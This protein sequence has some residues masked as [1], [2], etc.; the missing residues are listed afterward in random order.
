MTQPHRLVHDTAGAD[1]GEATDWRSLTRLGL[2]ALVAGGAVGVVGAAFR[3]CLEAANRERDALIGWARQWPLVGW[4]VPV[5][6]AALLVAVA[7][8]LVQRFAPTAAGSGVQHVEAVMRGE[9]APEPAAVLPVKFVGGVL[10]IGSGLVLGREGPTV[11]IG[12][13]VGAVAARLLRLAEG[14]ARTLQ[15]AGAGAGLAVAFNAPIGG[16]A[17]VVEELT[18]TFRATTMVAA[19]VACASAGA[20]SRAILGNE[21]A[22]PVAP[23]PLPP[24]GAVVSG[25]VLGALL[26]LVGAAYNRAVLLWLNRFAALDRVPVPARA[27][28][29]GG[30]VGLVA[31]F[32]PGLVGGGEPLVERTLAGAFP[33]STLAL[34][35]AAR[36]LLGPLSYATGAPGG[37]FAPLLVIGAAVGTML[38]EVGDRLWPALALSPTTA[39][40]VG[41]AAFFTAVVRAPLTGCLLVLG[42]TGTA[43]PLLPMLA[44]CAAAIVVTAALGS[45]P[46]YDTLR[47]RMERGWAAEPGA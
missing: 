20:T 12:A 2:A 37:L 23:L 42:M 25:L 27:A 19:L 38:A 36:W 39:A 29:I 11:Q 14:E 46:I 33:L 9:A 41:M 24:V 3:L 17:F 10:A 16:V 21:L 43:T 13:T 5:A 28:A 4:V 47:Q 22:L 30:L 18:K 7:A 40:L 45:A 44:A 1:P 8:W 34:L 31:W 32:E 35:V 15:G 6:V 26:G